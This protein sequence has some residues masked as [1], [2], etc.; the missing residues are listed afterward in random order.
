MN[1]K[2]DNAAVLAEEERLLG[3]REFGKCDECGKRHEEVGSGGTVSTRKKTGSKGRGTEWV[4]CGC[5]VMAVKGCG[6]A[7]E[8]EVYEC[9][10]CREAGAGGSAELR[11]LMREV[12]GWKSSVDTERELRIQ[13]SEEMR[14]RMDAEERVKVYELERAKLLKDVE[15]WKDEASKRK[16]GEAV[17]EEVK[18][19][20]LERGWEKMQ[21]EEAGDWAEGMTMVGCSQVGRVKTRVEEWR[22]SGMKSLG[23]PGGRIGDIML[24]EWEGEACLKEA[25]EIVLVMPGNDIGNDWK[26]EEGSEDT[27]RY[28]RERNERTVQASMDEAKRLVERVREKGKGVYVVAPGRRETDKAR[29]VRWQ[30]GTLVEPY[31]RLGKMLKEEYEGKEGVKGVLEMVEVMGDE[32][33]GLGEDGVHLDREGAY[34]VWNWIRERKGMKPVDVPRRKGSMEIGRE[35]REREGRGWERNQGDGR[36][37]FANEAARKRERSTGG[38]ERMR[39]DVECYKCYGKGHMARNCERDVG[40]CRRCGLKND[41][42]EE[43]CNAKSGRCVRCDKIGHYAAVCP[44]GGKRRK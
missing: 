7:G 31:R 27:I 2:D 33:K 21:V 8:K 30:K 15:Y 24:L 39:G 20:G 10:V 16:A 3:V 29:D 38:E 35:D 4:T 12:R 11:A 25:K 19:M 44:L 13:L 17:L 40:E 34:M 9:G 14:K 37:K 23:V 22:E 1:D 43:R 18:M 5:G 32:G 36:V 41:H 42:L 26:K 6:Q 28:I